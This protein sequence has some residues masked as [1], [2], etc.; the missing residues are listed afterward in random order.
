MILRRQLGDLCGS[1]K[2]N[3]GHAHVARQ[4]GDEGLG[5]VLRGG[6]PAGFDVGGAHAARHIHGQHDGLLLRG[7]AQHGDGARG[8]HQQGGK[9]D[10]A[11]QRRNVAAQALAH[12]HGFAHQ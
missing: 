7:Q 3:N 2:R 5:R 6:E 1:G 4:L 8:S 11:E 12:A 9:P 10:Q